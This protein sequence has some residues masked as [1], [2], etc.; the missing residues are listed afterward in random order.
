M[1]NKFFSTTIILGTLFF[2][3]L[4]YQISAAI[5]NSY[6]DIDRKLCYAIDDIRREIG[7]LNHNT[8]G[9]MI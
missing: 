5:K 2:L 9:F 6:L 1:P 4:F 3:R 8:M 7:Q